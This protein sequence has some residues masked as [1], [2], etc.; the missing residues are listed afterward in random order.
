MMKFKGKFQK[1]IFFLLRGEGRF[2]YKNVFFRG[3]SK[4]FFI[5]LGAFDRFDLYGAVV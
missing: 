2:F 4:H 5:V 1:M 3:F